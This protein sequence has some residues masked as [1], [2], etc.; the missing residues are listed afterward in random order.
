[1]TS[2]EK[3]VQ[4]ICFYSCDKKSL[5]RSIVFFKNPAHSDIIMV[6]VGPGVGA[7]IIRQRRKRADKLKK[8]QKVNKL[9]GVWWMIYSSLTN[10][11]I[12]SNIHL[13]NVL[14]VRV[15]Y[16][17]GVP[18]IAA[19]APRSK[20]K[21]DAH[22]HWHYTPA[23]DSQVFNR[24]RSAHNRSNQIRSASSRVSWITNWM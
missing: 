1:M 21:D 2:T 10:A 17:H 24:K 20:K 11:R 12:C 23:R 4:K 8:E 6:G 3:W 16:I 5:E 7:D 13:D 14:Q 9:F 18:T 15:I 19:L 22:Y